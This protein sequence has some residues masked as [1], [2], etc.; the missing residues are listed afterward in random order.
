MKSFDKRVLL[1]GAVALLIFAVGTAAQKPN[2][3][4]PPAQSAT[5]S[6][7]AAQAQRV[8]PKPAPLEVPELKFE[9]YKLQNGLVVILSEDHRLPMV[10]VNL[11]Y[12][13]GPAYE[14]PGKTGFAHLFE[15]M[16]FEGS[17]HVPGNAHFHLLEAA[18]A[19]D[20]NGTT[21]FDRTNYF[22]T[23]PANQLE[24][25]LWLES[26]R[27]GYLP[28]KLDQANLSN[29]QDVVRN[30]RR[31]SVENQPYGIVEEG[32][33]HQL[34]PKNHPYYADVIGS[35]QDIQSAKLE[36][37]RN[38]FK[39]YYAPNNASLA[40][41]GDFEPE[42]A[43]ELV[44]KYFGPLKRGEE[45]PRITAKTPPITAERRAV[46]QDNVQLPRVYEA[47][48]TSPI[49]KPGD[50]EADL[51]ATVLGGGKS[52]RLYK[53]LVYE[54]QIALD[55]AANQQP[56]MLGSEF[57]VQA[58]ARPGVK[59]EDLEKAINAELEAFRTNGPTEEE[60]K[61][62]RNVLESR[63]IEGLET[64]GGFGGV[65]DRL[66]SYNHYLGT[67]DFLGA[68]I[69]RYESASVESLKAFA[70]NQLGTNQR[71]V[72]YGV[73]GKQDL[74]AEVP[75][76][77]AE[78]KDT[79][80]LGGEPVNPDAEWRKDPPKPGPAIP[81]H[82]PV[83][84]EF[85]LSNGLTVLYNERPGLPVVAASLVLRSGS[86]ANPADKPG[87]ASFT[88]RMLQQGTTTRNALQIADSA[89]DLGASLGSRASMDSSSVGTQ[90]L[91]RN[92]PEA[93]DLLAD[94]A[95]HPT[96]PKDEIERVRKEREAALVQ[97]QDDPFSV[98]T[99][100]MR[101]ALYGPHN[102][103]GYPDIGT[104]ESL[105]TI[106]REDLLKFWQEH[107][108]P[109]DAAIIVAGN[110]KLAT[111][112]PLLEKAF[113]AWKQGQPAAASAG[114]LESSDARL[115][116]VDRPGAPQTTL[117][118]YELGAARSTPDYAPLE[119]VN[120]ELGGLFSSR[121]NMNLREA[122]GYTYG[123]GSTF[124]Y[125]RRPG[126]FLA[127]SAVRTDVTAPATTEIFNEL[128]RMR[129]TQMTPEEMKLSKDSITRSM[130]GRFERGS[131]AVGTFAELFIYDLPL[132]YFSKF[133]DAVDA[134][135]PEQA[136]ATAQKYIH[137]EKIAVVAVG[138][139]SKIEDEMKKLNLGKIEIRDPEGNVV[140]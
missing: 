66:N 125:H 32:L 47:W 65:A 100:V 137:P 26:D 49:F 9:K 18:G 92:F 85:K 103:Y 110:V 136:E 102:S 10:A 101:N 51:T 111:L 55:V 38:F 73:P 59:P 11:W 22:E 105:K 129:D 91:T 114:T 31:Q 76:P 127:Y 30:E 58:T 126:P 107:Y 83:P 135:T 42:H 124:A 109:N 80:K 12:H 72:V 131:D 139:R 24:L 86:G 6:P 36:D 17:R 90:V 35:H 33:F 43:K 132:D 23:L 71:V 98:A 63:I 117:E 94:V 87:L 19:S 1:L 99:R 123:A 56:L 116:L 89:A 81:L 13:V 68:D 138:D 93:L 34:F 133:P 5:K 2:S 115:I 104:T 28:D 113:G 122:H 128:K 134:V 67:P 121:I 54:K 27:M 50:A 64:L 4:Q 39:L 118:C 8:A 46:I 97:E 75:T 53:K 112:K 40:I 44:E 108:F 88:A 119:V 84:Q 57:Q 70:Q 79:A 45:V 7:T 96:F 95:L 29:Q 69:A 41:V 62:A 77:K 74:G 61:R 130:P 21:D 120:T 15:H 14:T 52:S 106:S 82:L 60:L 78:A 16:M 20:I 48:L 3:S 25:A 140:H 37:V